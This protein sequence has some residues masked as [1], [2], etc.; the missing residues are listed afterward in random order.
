MLL[1]PNVIAQC[2]T[3]EPLT[4][5]EAE[6]DPLYV[7]ICG[8]EPP[9]G[10]DPLP[11]PA[12]SSPPMYVDQS[13]TAQGMTLTATVPSGYGNAHAVWWKAE[14]LN[15]SGFLETLWTYRSVQDKPADG[16]APGSQVTFGAPGLV[17]N[18]DI[19][20]S[21]TFED[22]NGY[23]L[24]WS[25]RSDPY[26]TDDFDDPNADPAVPAGIHLKVQDDFD[27]PETDSQEGTPPGDGLGPEAVWKAVPIM[28]GNA[29]DIRIA[30]DGTTAL[31]APSTDITYMMREETHPHTFHE[32]VVRV[33]LDAGNEQIPYNLQIQ[34]RIGEVDQAT[35]EA[36]SYGVKLVKGVRHC[37]HA[38]LIAFRLPDEYAYAGCDEATGLP[39]PQTEGVICEDPTTHEEPPLEIEDPDPAHAGLSRPVWLRIE[40]N[41]EG[42]PP[43]PR[44]LGI[45]FWQDDQGQWRSCSVDRTDSGDPG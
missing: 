15:E 23:K 36:P 38:S 20:F 37:Q 31:V 10:G 40:V 8:L 25:G 11:C 4:A 32:A 22:A 24:C 43:E 39:W 5:P 35:G 6:G 9:G 2:P 30:E 28:S 27:R 7:Q 26:P 3:D 34:A 13:A 17:E 16:W 18:A 29:H 1:V 42:V 12:P 45:V 44:V 19:R 33:D 21:V 41:D 14:W